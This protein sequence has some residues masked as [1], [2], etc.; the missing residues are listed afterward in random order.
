LAMGAIGISP[1]R[2]IVV[3]FSY[4]YLSGPPSGFISHE[5]GEIPKYMG[6]IW[7]FTS[8]VWASL[9]IGSVIV[10]LAIYFVS[11]NLKVRITNL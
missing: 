9:A 6:I 4:P 7:P 8:N 11:T 3:D 2:T 5:P 1:S 10:A